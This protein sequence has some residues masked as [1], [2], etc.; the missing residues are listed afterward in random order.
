MDNDKKL[1]EKVSKAFEKVGI[2][3]DE[4]INKSMLYIGHEQI[5]KL[6]KELSQIGL[7]PEVLD[8]IIKI[9]GHKINNNFNS[10]I[11]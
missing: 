8:I 6:K 2:D 7:P 4:S 3:I 5:K 11:H 10:T 9:H 1:M